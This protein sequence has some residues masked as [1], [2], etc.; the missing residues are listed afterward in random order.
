M[1]DDMNPSNNNAVI[2]YQTHTSCP[3]GSGQC[4]VV[5]YE[6]FQMLSG[7]VAG[8]FQAILYDEGDILIQFEDGGDEQGAYAATGVENIDGTDGTDYVCN[9]GV[10][11]LTDSLAICFYG[12]LTTGCQF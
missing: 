2:Y 1:W 12:E 8:T 6:D 10:G 4:L 7:G 3:V 11:I 9:D 5:Q